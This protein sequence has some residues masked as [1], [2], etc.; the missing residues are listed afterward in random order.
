MSGHS[1]WHSIRHKKG[2]ADAKRAQKF[3]KLANA[4]AI[5]AR[6]GGAD[7]DAN[8]SLRLA[9]DKAKAANMPKDNIERAIQRG[10]GS[11][12]D[13]QLETVVYEGMGPG[14]AFVLVEAVT[15]NR[16]RTIASVKTLFNK[17]GGNMD[18]KVMWQFDRKGVVL[19]VSPG[20]PDTEQV[21]LAFIEAGAEDIEWEEKNVYIV[22][23]IEDLQTLKAEV[24]KQGFQV[25]QAELR[26][27][28]KDYAELSDEDTDKL[29][30][31]IDALEEDDDVSG[32]YVNVAV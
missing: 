21:E 18:A 9:V 6:E 5:S 3:T 1:K 2:A 11:S 26:Y 14:G 24:E 27:L 15:D 16:N 30:L 31:F 29:R 23:A 8:F 7:V 20:D 28:P 4:I 19:A 13:G 32:V 22:C 12:T 25:E 17:N 10:A